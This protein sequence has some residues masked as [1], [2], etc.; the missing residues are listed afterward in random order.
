MWI[1]A[2]LVTTYTTP[3]S[4]ITCKDIYP[5]YGLDLT[6]FERQNPEV[7]LSPKP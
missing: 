5:V 4:G 7:T 6:S 3:A 1:A 2:S